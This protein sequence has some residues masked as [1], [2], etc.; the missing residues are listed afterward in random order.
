MVMT[1][2]DIQI[3][4]LSDFKLCRKKNTAA[5]TKKIEISHK[6]RGTYD[7]FYQL[8]HQ[9]QRQKQSSKL[10]L[11]TSFALPEQKKKTRCPRE[12]CWTKTPNEHCEKRRVCACTR[13]S[14]HAETNCFV[15]STGMTKPRDTNRNASPI[16]KNRTDFALRRN[17]WHTKKNIAAMTKKNTCN[18]EQDTRH[19]RFLLSVAWNPVPHEIVE[20]RPRHLPPF[21]NTK[22]PKICREISASE[23]PTG[24]RAR[25]REDEF[26]RARRPGE[27][28][29]WEGKEKPW[30]FK[31]ILLKKEKEQRENIFYILPQNKEIWNLIFLKTFSEVIYLFIYLFWWCV[32]G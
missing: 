30:I 31:I 7:C 3:G 19:L 32:I 24:S 13:R 17:A 21:Q 18:V 12:I 6:M 11:A 22:Q 26:A 20:A 25:A 28:S 15:K 23:T 27:K 14:K 29:E 5:M 4:T 8:L 16:S 2:R 10:S 1:N 9:T